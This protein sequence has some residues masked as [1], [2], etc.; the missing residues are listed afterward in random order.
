MTGIQVMAAQDK[1]LS[2]HLQQ[3][4]AKYLK[5]GRLEHGLLREP[6]SESRHH[7]LVASA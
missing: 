2:L 5:C 6:C 3:E 4:F 1:P 7:L